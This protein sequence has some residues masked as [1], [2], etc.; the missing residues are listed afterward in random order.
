M[1]NVIEPL[2]RYVIYVLTHRVEVRVGYRN[3]NGVGVGCSSSGF[4][5]QKVRGNLVKVIYSYS[6]VLW[7]RGPPPS[8]SAV[9][10]FENSGLA[11]LQ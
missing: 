3:W 11:T 8:T 2:P 1:G 7:W 6:L 5:G 10:A 4:V 9:V